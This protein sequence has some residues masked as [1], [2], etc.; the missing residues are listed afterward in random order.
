M[1]NEYKS[2]KMPHFE[3]FSKDAYPLRTTFIHLHSASTCERRSKDRNGQ[4]VRL[5]IPQSKCC[6]YYK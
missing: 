1:K 6:H 5:T 3:Y 2:A 4:F